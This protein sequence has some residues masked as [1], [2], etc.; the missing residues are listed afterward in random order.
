MSVVVDQLRKRFD[1]R[2][3]VRSVSFSVNP[4]EVYGLIGPNGAG[5]TTTMRMLVGL[6]QPSGGSAAVCGV[7]VVDDPL[8]V[9][10]SLGF[11][12]GSTG[13]YERLSVCELLRFYGRLYGLK[14][15]LLN[16]RIARVVEQLG[17]ASLQ[18]RR[19]GRLSTGERQRVS[20]ARALVHDPQVL[21]F[22]EPTAGLDVLASGFVAAFI[23]Q[24]RHD[25]KTVLFSTH[26]MTEAE[27]LCDRIGLLHQ[28]RLVAEG[29]AAALK[30]RFGA[31]SL[32]EIFLQL[33]GQL[34]TRPPAADPGPTPLDEV[35]R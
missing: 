3:A 13:L 19:C 7:D 6:M 25:G 18:Q 12:T 30:E 4:S 32:E 34:P 8:R 1:E 33:H 15:P 24:A 29:S 5:K 2:W 14:E 35:V 31:N 17:I 9:R 22:D 16:E 11:V 28:G 23:R 26:Y 27:L 10:A 21:V 20:L